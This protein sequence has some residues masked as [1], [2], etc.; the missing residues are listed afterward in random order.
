MFTEV[1]MWLR[2]QDLNELPVAP[3]SACLHIGMEV[4]NMTHQLKQLYHGFDTVL[5]RLVLLSMATYSSF[6]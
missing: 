4:V 5:Y 6:S 3:P 1:L 2:T